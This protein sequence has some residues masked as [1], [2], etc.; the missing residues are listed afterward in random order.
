MLI[1]NARYIVTQNPERKILEDVDI[2]IEDNKIS[3]IGKNLSKT[4]EIIDAKN[5]IIIP[6][7]INCHTHS[8]MSLFRGV[9]DDEDLHDWLSKSIIPLEKNM[10]DEKVYYGTLLSILEKI[11]TGT[12]TFNEMYSY[13]ETI[14]KAVNKSGIRALLTSGL[15][16]NNEESNIDREIKKSKE[17]IKLI[18]NNEGLIKPAFSL[19]W[20]LTCSDELIRKV[21]EINKEKLPLHMHISETK[22]EVNENIKRFGLRPFERLDELGVLTQN[23][24]GLHSVHLS[25]KE[26]ELISKNNCK[27]VHNPAANMKLADGI[28]P[29]YELLQKNVCVSLGTDSPASNDNLNLFEEMKLASLLQ[30]VY[31]ENASI[32]NAQ[33]TFDLATINAAK[34]LGMENQ[35]GSIEVGKFADLVFIDKNEITINPIHGKK[36]LISN[37]IYSF[38]GRVSDVIVD[39][40]FLLRNYK[41][42]TLDKRRIIDKVKTLTKNNFNSNK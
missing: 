22:S 24:I 38:D 9:S 15:K 32:L 28:C 27:I 35:I 2:L 40:K 13:I 33:E 16:D 36:G 14:I 10:D 18:K 26:I 12:T 42:L 31:Y 39:G 29:V 8:P 1:K 30:K 37:L 17:I 6:G 11:S 19:H 4:D 23:F 7:L 34:T 21:Y 5:K 20:T 3:N 25:K 41:F